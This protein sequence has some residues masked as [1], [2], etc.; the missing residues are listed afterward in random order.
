M[1][2]DNERKAFEEHYIANYHDGDIH[3]NQQLLEWSENGEFYF[4]TS[5]NDLWD[6]WQASANREGYKLV[7]LEPTDIEI[8]SIKEKHWG[9]RGCQL[10]KSDYIDLYKAMIGACDE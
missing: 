8:E 6:M 1:N 2:L 7:P 10:C 5:V 3:P 4:A 9:M